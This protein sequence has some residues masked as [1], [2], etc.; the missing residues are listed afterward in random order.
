MSKKPLK[1]TLVVGGLTFISRIF[2]YVRDAVIFILFGANAGTD[3]FFVAF[4]I[5]NFLRRLFAEGAFSQAFVPVMSEK[6]H[7]SDNAFQRLI[8][9]VSGVLAVILLIVTVIGVLASPVFI[10]IFAPGF[11]DPEQ[12]VLASDMLKITFPYLL[13]ISLTAMSGS[14]LNIK[15]RFAVPAL[16]PVLLNISLIAAAIW[17]A[18]KLE[19]PVTALA[20]GVFIAGIAQLAF[21][22]PFLIRAKG[23]PKFKLSGDQAGVKQVFTLMLPAIFGASIVQINL[24]IDTIIASFLAEG[25]ISWLYI[26]DRFV[27]LPLALFGIATAT[28]ILPLLSK[29]HVAQQSESFSHTMNWAIRLSLVIA[30]PAMMGLVALASPI[31]SSLVQYR[32]FTPF[33]TQMASLSLMAY[34][35]GLPAFIFIKILAP[36]FFSRQDTKTPVKIGVIAMLTNIVLNLL[37]VWL[38]VHYEITGSHAGLALATSLSAYVNAALLYI[39]LHRQR[40]ITFMQSTFSLANKVFI[41]AMIMF[42]ILN[43]F[44]PEVEAWASWETDMRVGSLLGFIALGVV[45]YSWLLWALGIKPSHLKLE[46]D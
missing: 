25:S 21:Q 4:R 33:D 13:F 15:Q 10:F 16:T 14:I 18:P 46:S 45:T 29:Q 42:Y 9:H 8:N 6:L 5:P 27:E 20:W 2:G 40:V 32:E 44:L 17:L 35:L 1:S 31:L 37:F 30:I 22:I 19:N 26:S 36:A 34:A 11:D 23:F 24:L 7:E 39:M 28:V 43:K 3:A 12:Q 41:S 38:F